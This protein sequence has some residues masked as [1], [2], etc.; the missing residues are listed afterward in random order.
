MEALNHYHP[1]PSDLDFDGNGTIT[2]RERTLYSDIK[3]EGK[4]FLDG[5][6]FERNRPRDEWFGK[7]LEAHCAWQ[8][9]ETDAERV[10]REASARAEIGGHETKSPRMG[11]MKTYS[12]LLIAEDINGTGISSP[13]K[14][15][16]YGT[17]EDV[18]QEL[19][20]QINFGEL[21]PKVVR[22]QLMP[23][24]RMKE[25]GFTTKL[26]SLA[27]RGGGNNT[28]SSEGNEQSIMVASPEEGGAGA[29]KAK[30]AK[31]KMAEKAIMGGA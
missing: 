13:M 4:R 3:D 2:E 7:P 11:G 9:K 25:L 16:N 19:K 18:R 5:L 22:E 24:K 30:Y 26:H 14:D 15:V 20:R 8:Q 23:K 31:F 27:D 10:N 21:N 6:T 28:S 29:R 12:P 17:T 1:A